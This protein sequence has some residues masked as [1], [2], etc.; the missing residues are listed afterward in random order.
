MKITKAYCSN[1][2]GERRHEILHNEKI[3]FS[4]DNEDG[5]PIVD[6][7]N[8]YN[9]LKCCGCE[10]IT[11]QH[12]HWFSE[13][14]GDYGKP[15]LHVEYYPHATYR[16]EPDWLY[17]LDDQFVRSLLREIYSSLRNGTRCLAAMGIRAVLEH[18]MIDKV[19]DNGSFVKNLSKFKEE[20]FISRIQHENLELIIEAGHATMHRAFHPNQEQL[21]ALVDIT[22]SVLEAIYIN[23]SKAEVLKDKIPKRKKRK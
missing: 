2:L 3:Y 4:Q 17:D 9:L 7:E 19:D 22:E 14:I 8:I 13:D 23:A 10:G 6:G 20:G 18:V 15:V 1:C 16:A 5:H 11:L 21:N 12:K